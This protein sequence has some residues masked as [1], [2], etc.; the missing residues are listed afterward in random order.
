MKLISHRGNINGKNSLFENHPPHIQTL[1]SSGIDVEV[2]VWVQKNGFYLGHDDPQYK[3][4]TA[5]LI[6]NC[7][8]L[9]C[10]AKS[11]SSLNAMLNLNV[12][13]CFW[14][15]KDEFTLTSKGYIWQAH[16]RDICGKSVIVDNSFN[17]FSRKYE[18]SPFAICSDFLPAI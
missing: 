13:N 14:H 10:H 9:W 18:T 15:D 2:D 1:I 16:K 12:L 5:F 8:F 11:L 6:K 4:D 3:I 17:S 7:N